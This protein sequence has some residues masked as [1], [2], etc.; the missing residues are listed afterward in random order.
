MLI[1]LVN[2]GN[3]D[4]CPCRQVNN[5][6][7]KDA[8]R[9]EWLSWTTKDLD[10][11]NIS[12]LTMNVGELFDNK[13]TRAGCLHFMLWLFYIFFTVLPDSFHSKLFRRASFEL[14]QTFCFVSN[15]LCHYSVLLTLV[16]LGSG[17]VQLKV[18][19]A[20]FNLNRSLQSSLF[21]AHESGTKISA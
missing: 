10:T 11:W 6:R 14:G 3:I 5:I 1:W 12:N 2:A 15:V 13:Y 18:R 16:D 8:R 21:T 19:H 4:R 20:L 17:G 7:A 9:L